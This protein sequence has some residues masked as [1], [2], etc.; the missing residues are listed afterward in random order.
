VGDVM[1][2]TGLEAACC[3]HVTGRRVHVGLRPRCRPRCWQGRRCL[4]TFR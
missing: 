1:T 3:W 4:T 2:R